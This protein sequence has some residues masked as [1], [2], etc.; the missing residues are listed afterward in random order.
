V[1]A[2]TYEGAQVTALFSEA[3]TWKRYFAR[4]IRPFVNGD[5]LEV[6]SGGGDTTPFVHHSGIASWTC[7]E[8]DAALCDQARQRLASLGVKVVQ[9]DLKSLSSPALF[10]TV[11]YLDVLEHIEDDGAEVARATECLRP[12]GHLVVLSPAHQFLFSPFDKRVGHH[13]RYNGASLRA[14]A[15]RGATLVQ[16]RY[17]DA[18]GLLASAANRVLLRSGTPERSQILLWDRVMVRIS[19]RLD[20]LLGHR[21]GKSILAVWRKD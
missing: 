1:N 2:Q 16:V 7:L 21:L 6:G 4:S 18:V 20:P 5:V 10:D 8:P 19:R 15:P 17:L 14:L 3:T 13:R 11:L 12:G 9:G